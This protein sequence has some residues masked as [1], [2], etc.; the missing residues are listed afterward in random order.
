M[1]G[2]KTWA[3]AEFALSRSAM[4]PPQCRGLAV[5][6][7]FPM[8]NT[9][10]IPEL[11][12]AFRRW[13]ASYTYNKMEKL[14][15]WGPQQRMFW[16][17]SAE[18]PERLSGPTVA[19]TWLDEPALTK[20]ETFKRLA[21]RVRDKEAAIT[22]M[23]FTGT[24][25]GVGNW[26]NLHVQKALANPNGRSRVVQGTTYD[27]V[28]TGPEFFRD[29]E[30]AYADDPAGRQN[31]ILGIATARTGNIYTCLTPDN[32][33][34]CE[35]PE[36]GHI[37]VGWDFNVGH[38]VTVIGAWFES[39]QVLHVFGEVVSKSLGGTTT[40]EHA[41][42]V[43]SYLAQRGLVVPVND[44]RGKRLLTRQ[45][46]KQ[47]DAC[48]DASGKNKH[49]SAT[50]SDEAHVVAAGFWPMHDNAN[51]LVRNRISAVQKAL[52]H[53]RL[54]IDPA[55]AP[56]TLQ[57]IREHARDE[58]GNPK[59][60]WGEKEMPL[61]HYADALGYMVWQLMPVRAVYGRAS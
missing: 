11:E 35:R 31:Y 1:G 50:K 25:E 45:W 36:A 46:K 51:P 48:I 55:G 20:E 37:V 16:L 32:I 12:K 23:L 2:G 49:S 4:N 61:D 9:N 26:L 57:A 28:H 27:N 56:I 58:D 19:W 42:R 15:A 8:V 59:K 33:V 14:F 18:E 10:L 43:A 41:E 5:E 7:T 13:H 17:R 22:Q 44:G 53:Q 24:H 34:K 60:K 3:G 38:M 6:P 39:A 52:R 29:I 21:T 47:V 30:D 54:L 40:E